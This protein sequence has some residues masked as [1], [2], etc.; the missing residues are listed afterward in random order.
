MIT[1]IGLVSTI[2][3][4]SGCASIL[5][6][7]VLPY[8]NTIPASGDP[9]PDHPAVRRVRGLQGD[10]AK[11]LRD[12]TTFGATTGSLLLPLASLVAYKGAT[13]GGSHN[14]AALSSGGFAGYGVTQYLYKRPR[15]LIYVSG[16]SAMDC[17]V[18]LAQPYLWISKVPTDDAR[19]KINALRPLAAELRTELRDQSNP[20]RAHLLSLVDP[21]TQTAIT[22]AIAG[23]EDEVDL[24][25]A[26]LTLSV[27]RLSER[28]ELSDQMAA[29][30]TAAAYRIVGMVNQQL[31]FL[32]PDPERIQSQIAA[33]TLPVALPATAPP[34]QPLENP[35]ANTPAVHH[36]ADVAINTLSARV[37]AATVKSSGWSTA[38]LDLRKPDNVNE[39]KTWLTNLER[40]VFK[41]ANDLNAARRLVAAH[42]AQQPPPVAPP[43]QQDW[44]RCGLEMPSNRFE[45][46]IALDKPSITLTAGGSGVVLATG[47]HG[48]PV[49]RIAFGPPANQQSALTVA[50]SSYVNGTA[51]VTVTTTSAL[52]PDTYVINIDNAVLRVDVS[53]K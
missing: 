35:A 14:I 12:Q 48:T 27:A 39:A 13:G 44:E 45:A 40:T 9:G 26:R 46:S 41:A 3:L 33:L 28:S 29:E 36:F 2:A 16:L 15:E 30:L 1:R 52:P 18:T 5:N 7:Y 47:G 19:Q 17:A 49:I 32:A 53:A 24:L 21:N 37:Q 20:V 38:E 8:E 25:D 51:R 43:S 31:A 6:P 50:S 23:I 42:E 34:S 4:L 11:R 10:I 22:S